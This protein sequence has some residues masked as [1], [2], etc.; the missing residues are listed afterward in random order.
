M[1]G[2]ARDY[3]PTYESIATRLRTSG[4][5][6]IPAIWQD[7]LAE[8]RSLVAEIERD[9]STRRDDVAQLHLWASSFCCLQAQ[10]ENDL[11]LQSEAISTYEKSLNHFYFYEN[12]VRLIQWLCEATRLEEASARVRE[13][14]DRSV[15]FE[16]F[17]DPE[18][19]AKLLNILGK[20]PELLHSAPRSVLDDALKAVGRAGKQAGKEQ[21]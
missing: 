16:A 14:S 11:K 17:H 13:L 15:S 21:A 20:Y 5:V 8:L 19:A 12:A 1:H 2:Y 6:V 18:C 3:W 9:I 4:S 10:I 7:S